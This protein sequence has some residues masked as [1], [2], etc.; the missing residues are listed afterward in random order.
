MN[1]AQVKELLALM[2]VGEGVV[3]TLYPQRY[4][5][6]WKTG[7]RGWRDFVAWWSDRP[8]LLRLICAAELGVGIWLADRQL[9]A[10]RK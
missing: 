9:G 3:G 5:R 8:A 1:S 6:L 7:P 2:L 10:E 4:T